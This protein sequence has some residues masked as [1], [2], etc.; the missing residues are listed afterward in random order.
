MKIL[1]VHVGG[2]ECLLMQDFYTYDLHLSE[3]GSINGLYVPDGVTINGYPQYRHE[4]NTHWRCCYGVNG[5]YGWCIPFPDGQ[6]Y[7]AYEKGSH[8]ANPT[9]PTGTYQG[10]YVGGAYHYHDYSGTVIEG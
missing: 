4:T 1:I 10:C 6:T 8:A 3:Y 9:L 7:N 5:A 2:E